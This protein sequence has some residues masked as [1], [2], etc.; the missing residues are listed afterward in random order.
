MDPDALSLETTS[1]T[2]ARPNLSVYLARQVL[3][4][5]RDRNLAPGDRLPSLKP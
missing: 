2:A 1:T 5:I 4:M 3:A